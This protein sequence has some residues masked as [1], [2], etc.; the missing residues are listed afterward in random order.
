L[1]CALRLSILEV[2]AGRLSPVLSL[3]LIARSSLKKRGWGIGGAWS[4]RCGSVVKC[5]VGE[6]WLSG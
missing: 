6:M 5:V 4:E 3:S 2:E 1:F